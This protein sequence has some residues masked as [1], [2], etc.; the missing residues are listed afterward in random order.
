MADKTSVQEASQ[1][2]FCALADY[3]GER[4]TSKAFD[5][6]LYKTYDEF[7][8]NYK[9]PRSK[10]IRDLIQ[11]SYSKKVESPGVKLSDIE[12]LLSDKKWFYSSMN[13]AKKMI[14]EVDS[15][16]NKFNRIKRV[17]WSDIF[18]VRGDADV[19]GSIQTLFSR[20]NTI[21]KQIAGPSVAFGNINK[22]SPADIY[23]ASLKAKTILKKT[24]QDSKNI[25]FNELNSLIEDLIN[26]GDLLPLSLKMQ[27]QN[28]TIEKVNFDSSS[29]AIPYEYAGIGGKESD[30]RSL[31]V[32]ISKTDK[33]KDLVFRH[34][35]S[36]GTTSG[37]T[38]KL[39][40]RMKTA[41]GGSLS[42]NQIADAFK[43]V[44]AQFGSKF[45]SELNSAKNGFKTEFMKKTQGITKESNGDLYRSI[46]NEV[47]K[48]Y[49]TD[50]GPN[51]VVAEYLEKN[52]R[53]GKS[54][55][56]IQS[57]ILAAGS[58]SEFSA[59]YVIAK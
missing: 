52:S 30:A 25:T 7:I 47:S 10:N 11:E 3:L 42:G 48:K 40:I 8:M 28:V 45:S 31:I 12:K 9:P 59:K 4:E 29:G 15:V 16:N 56:L 38:Y 57:I 51:K 19:M 27:P 58:K 23:F 46:R 1:A 49:F 22:W 53:N 41:R 5:K 24:V 14:E 33:S 17:D 18:Y 2:L 50:S 43:S 39:E 44:D 35:A 36:T 13:I 34:D 26:S 37:G 32:L 55:K 6:R 54:D 20:A 21:L